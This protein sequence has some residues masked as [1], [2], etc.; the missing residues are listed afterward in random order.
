MSSKKSS[1]KVIFL[2]NFEAWGPSCPRVLP[3]TSPGALQASKGVKI[4]SKR[5]SQGK[6]FHDVYVA[7]RA[8]LSYLAFLVCLTDLTFLADYAR[9][10]YVAHLA[11]LAYLAYS[12]YSTYT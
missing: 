9:S 7:H 6:V 5:S 12:A 1:Q 11:Q 2:I 10:A 3:R 4:C 8:Y